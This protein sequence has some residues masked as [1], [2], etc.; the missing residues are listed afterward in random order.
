MFMVG[1]VIW[2]QR[3]FGP[4][5]RAEALARAGND[6]SLIGRGDGPAAHTEPLPGVP[7]RWINGVLPLGLMIFG[8]AGLIYAFGASVLEADLAD[9]ASPGHA[10]A[11][12]TA[13]EGGFSWMRAVLGASD[14]TK[15]IFYGS[16]S[17]F[18]LAVIMGIGQRLLSA[19]EATRTAAHGIRILFKDAV[20]ILL[21]AWAIGKVCSELGTATY[22]VAAFQGIIDGAW[23][24]II[25]F[26]ASCFVAFA[27]GSS[28]TT[29]AIMQPNVVLL[30]YHLGADT[31]YGPH[32]LLILSIGAVLEGAI[33]GDHCSP[34]SD[35]TILSSA[36]S[37]CNHITHVR[38]QAPYAIVTAIIAI[39][40]GYMPT[41]LLDTP[42]W[43][44]IV[45]GCALLFSFMR[46]VAKPQTQT[47]A[48]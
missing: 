24:P 43:I 3:D 20:M 15:A 48:G 31:P 2:T 8:T 37:K 16:L 13:E 21:L 27:T 10:D 33:F 36:A 41:A 1:C 38:T 17:A 40:I 25:L 7:A 34:I 42:F 47:A 28:W 22:L 11:V 14:S 29:M 46:F 30:A 39:V 12:A 6:E 32:G 45:I 19:A 44:S 9:P 23:L 35:T 18:V 26:L 5:R 4:M